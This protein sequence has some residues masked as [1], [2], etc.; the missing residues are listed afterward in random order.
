MKGRIWYALISGHAVTIRGS[1]GKMQGLS[2][3]PLTWP[4]AASSSYT[5]NPDLSLSIASKAT[6]SRGRRSVSLC[7]SA[8]RGRG[9]KKCHKGYGGDQSM[10][11]QPTKPAPINITSGWLSREGAEVPQGVQFPIITKINAQKERYRSTI[12]QWLEADLFF[13]L[14]VDRSPS[15]CLCV[16]EVWKV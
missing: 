14:H 4:K 7:A 8:C 10:K 6:L 15:P 12:F 5:I 16:F 11:R 13:L 2:W 1:N 9:I 3:T